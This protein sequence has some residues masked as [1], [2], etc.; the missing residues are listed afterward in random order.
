MGG[1]PN[2]TPCLNIFDS[3]FY[4]VIILKMEHILPL[5]LTGDSPVSALRVRIF[6][7]PPSFP[8]RTPL[9][10]LTTS[11]ENLRKFT[12]VMEVPTNHPKLVH[13]GIETH[14][15]LGFPHI[16]GNAHVDRGDLTIENRPRQPWCGQK[17]GKMIER[18]LGDFPANHGADDTRGYSMAW[19]TTSDHSKL[20]PLGHLGSPW[21][22]MWPFFSYHLTDFETR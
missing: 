19:E 16:F 13:L 9:L 17:T 10:G 5:I 8:Q 3:Y 14:G 4:H 22:W 21:T 1:Y 7:R 20:Q 12:Q 2:L 6:C 18:L 15:D 11:L